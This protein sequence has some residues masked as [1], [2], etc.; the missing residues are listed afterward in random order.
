M[1]DQFLFVG[2]W[3]ARRPKTEKLDF[4]LI[5][6]NESEVC[7]C[8]HKIVE[9]VFST[10]CACSIFFFRPETSLEILS[11]NE[12]FSGR[13][14]RR[15]RESQLR[16]FQYTTFYGI[17][18]R[19]AFLCLFKIQFQIKTAENPIR[20]SENNTRSFTFYNRTG[21]RLFPPRSRCR[22]VLEIFT[23]GKLFKAKNSNLIVFAGFFVV[24]FHA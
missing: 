10:Q 9:R 1:I 23:F 19:S 3:A 18:T 22:L 20:K 21:H 7:A 2:A 12:V 8:I 24:G 11:Y 4:C 13:R 15:A 14:G 5:V 16:Y 6:N 17:E